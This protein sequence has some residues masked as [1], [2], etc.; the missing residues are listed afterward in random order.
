MNTIATYTSLYQQRIQQ[1]YKLELTYVNDCGG[2]S[3][4]GCCGMNGPYCCR[5]Q[6]LDHTYVASVTDVLDAYK[7]ILRK[8]KSFMRTHVYNEG[9]LCGYRYAW[10]LLYSANG[11]EYKDTARY[12]SHSPV[13]NMLMRYDSERQEEQ[14][15]LIREEAEKQLQAKRAREAE[16][17][18]KSAEENLKAD[19]SKRRRYK[20]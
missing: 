1:Q 2:D 20:Y 8:N 6:V 18:E 19:A 13:R 4:G 9:G 7:A 3:M 14:R 15:R 5:E 16:E 17:R 11:D 12:A 10:R